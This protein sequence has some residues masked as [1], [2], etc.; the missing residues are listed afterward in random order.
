MSVKKMS[1]AFLCHRHCLT[2]SSLCV[3]VQEDVG[4]PEVPDDQLPEIPDQ[5][6]GMNSHSIIYTYLM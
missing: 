4:L 1:S 3:H 6:P 2:L 5:E